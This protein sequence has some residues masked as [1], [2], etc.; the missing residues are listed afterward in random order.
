[1]VNPWIIL[2]LGITLGLVLGYSS[3]F[4]V[5]SDVLGYMVV[6]TIVLM[7]ILSRLSS[8][9]RTRR[10][11][12][13]RIALLNFLSGLVFGYGIMLLLLFIASG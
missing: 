6:V 3:S 2:A 4:F 1:M 9:K 5:S 7:L 12:Q 10:M 11:S 13:H 8:P